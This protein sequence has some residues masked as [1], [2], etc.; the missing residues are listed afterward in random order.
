MNTHHV[1][2]IAL[3]GLLLLTACAGPSMRAAAPGPSTQAA[4]ERVPLYVVR[5]GWH[6]DIGIARADMQ[7]PLARIAAVF[8]QARYLLFGFG[9]RR[10]L[11]EGGAGNAFGAL[12]GGAGLILVTSVGSQE[13]EQVFG[14]D[15]VVRLALTPEQMSALQAFIGCSFATRGGAIVLVPQGPHAVGSFS[16]FYESAQRY[17]ALHTCNTWAAEVLKSAALPVSS[18]GVEFAWQLW[19]QVRR[20]VNEGAHTYAYARGAPQA[21]LSVI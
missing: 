7:P 3:T 10:Y 2:A 20:L 5:R 19:L 12:W 4:H 6:I 13:P 16:A 18:S 14:R 11:L 9:D 17:S 8:P 21:L 15:S 1:N